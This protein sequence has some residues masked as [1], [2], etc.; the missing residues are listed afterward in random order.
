MHNRDIY[1]VIFFSKD[2]VAGHHHLTKGETILRSDLKTS[3]DDINDILE[4]YNIK[5]YIDNDLF[6]NNWT[7]EDIIYF[8]EKA[9]EYGKVTGQFMSTI[10]DENITGYYNQLLHGYIPS[11]WEIINNYKY[12]KQISHL[13]IKTIL[14]TEPHLIH[15]LL[16]HRDIVIHYDNTLRDFLLTFSH[17]AEILLTVYEVKR[18]F[19]HKEIFLPKSLSILDKENIL[20]N[21]LD[22]DDVNLNYVELIQTARNKKYELVISDK[23]RLKA[24][25]LQKLETEKIFSERGNGFGQKIGANIS[26]LENPNKIKE[27]TY[28]NFI[29]NYT[30]SIAFIKQHNEHYSLFRNFKILFEYIDSQNRINLVSKKSEMAIMERVIGVHSQ[31]EYR[32]GIVFTLSEISS[33]AQIVAYSNVINNLGNSLEE[34]I[35]HIYTSI[36]QAKYNFA[37]NARLSM[38]FANI[39]YFEKVRLLAPEFESILKQF[40]LFVEEKSIDFELLQISSSPSAIKE[41]PSLNNNKYFYLSDANKELM[42]C[43]NLFFS[44]QTLLAYVEPF[45]EKQYHSFFDLLANENV[46]FNNYE[47]YQK[48]QLK[49]LIDKGFISLDENNFI[50]ITNYERVLILK[51]LHDN[52][53]GSF[54]HYPIYFQ[55]EAKQMEALNMVYFESSLFSKPEQSYFNYLLNKS[56]FTNGLDLRN[57]YL[58]GTQ[59]NPEDTVKHEY[60]YF[61][62]LKLF[63]L[64]MLKIEDD[65]F[66]S[67]KLVPK[68]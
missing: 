57:S 68:P 65:L 5:K 21:Y 66:I 10:T 60:S 62:Y 34:I 15:T 37:S 67:L 26:F 14:S 7:N 43:Y 32:G 12:F 52:E 18:D 48:P 23:T 20:S 31:N 17:S 54:Y 44:D 50:Q 24:K 28:E 42:G 46:N 51:D 39:S 33:H 9:L 1:R 16:N 35:Q 49:Y 61:T 4:L 47:E 55:N 36:F 53:V 25:R 41:I 13:N 27:L 6:L 8:K 3:Y 63:V 2:D 19:N 29:A 64:V 40:K 45:K 11:F 59:A 30:Y 22:S 56:E 58:H 38:P